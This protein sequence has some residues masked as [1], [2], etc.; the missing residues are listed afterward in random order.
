MSKPREATMRIRSR[1]GIV[2]AAVLSGAAL[3]S[4]C[5]SGN[6][7]TVGSGGR[8]P[9]NG[10]GPEAGA[11]CLKDEPGCECKHEGAVIQCGVAAESDGG[12]KGTVKCAMGG[13]I[14]TGGRWSTCETNSNDPALQSS[15]G[16]KLITGI[17][18]KGLTN[19]GTTCSN[20]PC[21]PYC[22][23]YPDN[24]NGLDAGDG[25]TSVL[26][27]NEA[28]V[29]TVVT[30]GN[31]DAST[32]P[33]SVLKDAG[34]ADGE[35][36]IFIDLPPGSS[37]TRELLTPQATIKSADIYF[38]IDDTSSMGRAA[39]ALAAAL[40]NTTSGIIS[41]IKT[42]LPDN[43]YFGVGRFEDYYQN[44]YIGAESPT[45]PP[46]SSGCD[47]SNGAG[48]ACINEYNLPYQHL[49]SMQAETGG[50]TAAAVNWLTIDAFNSLTP[51]SQ[52]IAR[53]GGDIPEASVAA[54]WMMASGNGSYVQGAPNAS[55][56]LNNPS[57]GLD[58]WQ[59]PRQYWTG[60]PVGVSAMGT[61]GT[62]NVSFGTTN[63]LTSVPLADQYSTMAS[64]YVPC[65]V[66]SVQTGTNQT[67]W[68]CFRS[69]STPVVVLLSD[70]PGHEGPGGQYP[71]VN[72]LYTAN[73]PHLVGANPWPVTPSGGCPAGY[74]GMQGNV[75]KL[76]T[77]PSSD[78]GTT[79]AGAIGLPTGSDN[80]P[81]PGVYYGIVPNTPRAPGTLA[82]PDWFSSSSVGSGLFTINSTSN[83]NPGYPQRNS[84]RDCSTGD[85]DFQCT[86]SMS[87]AVTYTPTCYS[88]PTQID[89][90][91]T[92]SQAAGNSVYT[93]FTATTVPTQAAVSSYT[94]TTA[95]RQVQTLPVPYTE[96][97]YITTTSLNDV[98]TTAN[99]V[100]LPSNYTPTTTSTLPY[101]TI[102]W[103]STPVDSAGYAAYTTTTL[104]GG[105]NLCVISDQNATDVLTC[106]D[107]SAVGTIT[108]SPGECVTGVSIIITGESQSST[109]SLTGVITGTG[110][111]AAGTLTTGTAVSANNTEAASTG[112][113]TFCAGSTT[114]VLTLGVTQN[115]T[116]NNAS[117][118]V[119]QFEVQYQ[120]S[121]APTTCGVGNP[122]IVYAAAGS[123]KT[124]ECPT[125]SGSVDGFAITY[126]AGNSTTSCWGPTGCTGATP[127]QGGAAGTTSTCYAAC[128]VTNGFTG[129]WSASVSQCTYATCNKTGFT[130]GAVAGYC[131]P[132]TC[133]VDSYGTA[134]TW[135]AA[136][137][138]CTY[139]CPAAYPNANGANCFVACT[140]TNDT[141]TY[142]GTTETC[143]P[144][145]PGRFNGNPSANYTY[146][147]IGG[148][149]YS[150][151]A[152]QTPPNYLDTTTTFC[153]S[154]P[155]GSDMDQKL[156]PSSKWRCDSCSAGTL[157]TST[158]TTATPPGIGTATYAYQCAGGL[159]PCNTGYTATGSP[160][161][162]TCTATS[163]CINAGPTGSTYST[164]AGCP[165][166]TG[167]AG[168]VG[169]YT[170]Y[171][172]TGTAS[173]TGADPP[174]VCTCAKSV[175]TTTQAASSYASTVCGAY[176]STTIPAGQCSTAGEGAACGPSGGPPS[177]STGATCT[178]ANLSGGWA[179]QQTTTGATST[180]TGTVAAGEG[181][182]GNDLIYK[183]T[184]PAGVGTG[185]R[186]YYH[187]ALLRQGP[188]STGSTSGWVTGGAAGS[189]SGPLAD[190]KPFLYIKSANGFAISPATDSSYPYT[191]PSA[192]SASD[193]VSPLAGPNGPVVDCDVSAMTSLG[194]ASNV[195]TD[196]VVSELDGYLPS[197][198][199]ATTYYLVVDNAAPT[200]YTSGVAVP[201]FQYWLQVGGFDD[202]PLNA[203]T[204]E[205]LTQPS[206]NQMVT[207]MKNLQAQFVGVENSGL[208]CFQAGD[209]VTQANAQFE[210]RDFMEK[211]A[212]DVG[213]YDPTTNRPYVVP[214]RKDG[215]AC[216][217]SCPAANVTAG[218]CDSWCSTNY[219]NAPVY[220][221]STQSCAKTCATDADCPMST[222]NCQSGTPNYC[223]TGCAGGI[224]GLSCA[225]ASAV[226]NLTGN[227]KQNVYLRPIAVNAGSTYV[228][229]GA[230]CVPTLP[231][232][233]ASAQCTGA[234]TGGTDCYGGACTTTCSVATDCASG[235]CEPSTIAGDS[236][237][238]CISP[239]IFISSVQALSTSTTTT[240][241]QTVCG[242]HPK[243][244]PCATAMDCAG[245]PTLPT[246]L[247]SGPAAFTCGIGDTGPDTISPQ[248][249]Y[250]NASAPP[251][252]DDGMFNYCSP[253]S[254]VE[255]AVTFTMPFQR[256][257]AAQ[258]YE[259]DLGI[260]AGAGIIGRTR[261]ILENPALAVSDFYRDYDG[262]LVCPGG[263]HVVWGNF[264]YNAICPSDGIGDYSQIRFCAATAS[265]AEAGFP[266]LPSSA[267]DGATGCAPG[268]V[269]LG[270]AT[271]N[272][273]PATSTPS[274]GT[275]NTCPASGAGGMG[276]S[277][278]PSVPTSA[279]PASVWTACNAITS[280][281]TCTGTPG[282]AWAPQLGFNVGTVLAAEGLANDAGTTQ[283]PYLRIRMEFDPSTPGDVVA[284]FL[285][286]WNLDVDCV[287]SE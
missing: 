114:A 146:S 73:S 175:T 84:L 92:S 260:Y 165:A 230:T 148:T 221:S 277:C 25:G 18:T 220:D 108:L 72:E 100:I 24:A 143:T 202:A 269:L 48:V 120:T 13:E 190:V 3:V 272:Q 117:G 60:S 171:A 15:A 266:P 150:C 173:E 83:F 162:T 1:S 201:A 169:V 144:T 104:H 135:K 41:G 203:T 249:A 82:S 7:A 228:A 52:L 195:N 124:A 247:L 36:Y 145:C 160:V 132:T 172:L 224:A 191:I 267:T 75:C 166:S 45:F 182:F 87:G 208:S 142:S 14:C 178:A 39:T 240:G 245:S 215:T 26:G 218:T 44:P 211:I 153:D 287:P 239:A 161:G 273:N 252:D 254:Q 253:G 31:P 204:P 164:N 156:T 103:T 223:T 126:S 246:C 184:V 151:E 57:N 279:T 234:S 278:A 261:V 152:G 107:A 222:P 136:L 139:G 231:T 22:M 61:P 86:P 185:G 235:I 163:A 271:A 140:N 199:T 207:A 91:A 89:T 116:P 71:H 147:N 284:P 9:G 35:G 270:F 17:K 131:Y 43:T 212:Y 244:I 159:S 282:C 258:Q 183:F 125:C 53:S 233:P 213:S 154:C 81:L 85:D 283:D 134:G 193:I 259:F 32:A 167:T 68:P 4:A 90:V 275:V 248:P 274:L 251:Q 194:E 255:F 58:W 46:A 232:G 80:L 205:S 23:Q 141:R 30:T 237:S 168:A 115:F 219:P 129:A 280:T 16:L 5:S 189:T 66:G 256:S 250:Y 281:A 265:T 119:V 225:V 216:N 69:G 210:T 188:D 158:A 70:A 268:E 138:G 11:S 257:A 242:I 285:Y 206:Y 12:P 37:A 180:C 27:C 149:C 122:G 113:G 179:C 241:S 54:L 29:L 214:V 110:G 226:A 94:G 200:T 51:A 236:N 21:D 109:A 93:A 157:Q 65:G 97:S 38:L 64:A 96:T 50:A 67:T 49:I 78:T 88:N 20:D 59:V 101:G 121:L 106:Q 55:G 176:S 238:Y 128:P 155:V 40:T 229:P 262:N 56:P 174:G 99:G 217:P 98:Y 62:P 42:A 263:T 63:F 47:G 133:P 187:F 33:G 177:L 286:S 123:S 243:T 186:Y 118:D 74:G 192:A 95:P 105:S 111:Y 137:P 8:G 197:G 170:T 264:S 130:E 6:P 79:F 19:P 127:N 181:Y 77:D 28:S 198:S 76:T 276:Y 209:T 10:L 196:Y 34:L 102:A 2:L 112:T 227:L